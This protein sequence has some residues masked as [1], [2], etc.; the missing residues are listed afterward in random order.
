MAKIINPDQEKIKDANNRKIL[1]LLMKKRQLSKQDISRLTKISITT[2]T[3][4]IAR[5]IEDG[6]AEEAGVA[7]STG[8]RKPMIIRFL[9]DGRYAFGVDFASNHLTASNNI[10]VVL[11]N[12]DAEVKDEEIFNYNKF[13]KIDDIMQYIKKVTEDIEARNNLSGDTILGIGFSLPGPV[14]EVKKILELAPNLASSL[15]MENVDFKKYDNLF[16]YPIYV[17]NEANAAAYGELVMG[18]AKNKHNLVYLSINR[19]IGAGLIIRG[20]IYKGKNRRAGEIGHITV[21]SN[22][23]KC[24]CGRKDCWEIYAASGALIRNFNKLSQEKISDTEQFLEKLKRGDKVAAKVWDEYLNYLTIGINNIILGYD[25]HYIVIGGE[26]S[27]FNSLLMDPL[28]KRVFENNSFYKNGELEFLLS[29]LREDASLIG[30]AL[31]PFQKLFYGNNK[32]I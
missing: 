25:P 19:G 23:L 5:L 16:P 6:L 13:S 2:V 15:G 31:L 22:G 9:P 4:N 32:I 17:E 21:A 26:I 3:G 18:T 7:D 27:E 10:K 20:H 30:A 29:H 1:H 11:I 28:K 8:G 12:L 24:T 14:N